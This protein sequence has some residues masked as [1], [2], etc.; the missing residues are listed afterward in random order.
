MVMTSMTDQ[1]VC[2]KI[3]TASLMDRLGGE[4]PFMIGWGQA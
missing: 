4:R 1:I 2:I 3:K